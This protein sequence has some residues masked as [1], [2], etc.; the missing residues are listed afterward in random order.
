[1]ATVPLRAAPV[2]AATLRPTDPLPVP[3]APD[4]TVIHGTPLTAVHEHAAVVVTATVGVLALAST[5]SLVGAIEYEHGATNAACVRVNVCVAIVS[6][7]VRA[8]PVLAV[9]L[10]A[11]VPLPVPAAPEVTVSHGALLT[12]VHAQAAVVVTFTVPG[13]APEGTVCD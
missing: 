12:A 6:V 5:F 7:A 2:F 11:T 8:A 9:T 10:N 1:M 3:D 4:V 13:P